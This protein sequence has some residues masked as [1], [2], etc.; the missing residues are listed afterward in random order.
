MLISS[1]FLLTF[2]WENILFSVPGTHFQVMGIL[3]FMSG[4]NQQSLPIPFFLL[5]LYLFLSLCPFQ[6]YSIPK[7]LPTTLRFLT[8]FF[9]SY[10][11]LI[12][13]FNYICHHES[14]LQP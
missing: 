6:L 9:R 1:I 4:M 12:G 10:F 11:C 7:I 2:V 3:R 5:L 13:P 8:L 14:L